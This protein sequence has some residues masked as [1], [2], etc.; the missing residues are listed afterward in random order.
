[1]PRLL[2]LA[3]LG[4]LMAA[5]AAFAEE[6]CAVSG[7][8]MSKEAIAKSLQDRGFVQIRSLS[9]HNGCYEAKG[10]DSKGRRFELELNGGTGAIVNAE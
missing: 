1:M 6:S 3:A 8:V 7:P 9:M 10:I 5:P 4:C 2:F